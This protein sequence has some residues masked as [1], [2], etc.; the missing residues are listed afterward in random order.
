MLKLNLPASTAILARPTIGLQ[1]GVLPHESM[2]LPLPKSVNPSQVAH[3]G[4][5]AKLGQ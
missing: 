2:I 1:F 4:A 3:V 5:V